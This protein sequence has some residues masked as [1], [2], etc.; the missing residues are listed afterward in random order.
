M[1]PGCNLLY[2]GYTMQ[3]KLI[4]VGI[5]LALVGTGVLFYMLGAS[6][7]RANEDDTSKTVIVDGSK[8][9]LIQRPP[10]VLPSTDAR[11]RADAI[12]LKPTEVTEDIMFGKSVEGREMHAYRFGNGPKKIILVGGIHGGYEWNTALLAF[13]MIDYLTADPGRVPSDLEVIIIPVANPD[14]LHKALGVVDRFNPDEA[15]DFEYAYEVSPEDIVYASRF[16]AHNVDI[17]RNFAC[18][19]RA[20][21]M[22]REYPVDAGPEAFSEPEAVFLRDLFLKE[23]P[24]AALFFHSASNGVYA[25]SCNGDP[26]PSTM[27]LLSTYSTA[28]GYPKFNDYPYYEVTGD[29]ADW[30]SSQGVPAI[31]IELSTHN[32]TEWDKNKAGLNAVFALYSDE[33]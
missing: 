15:P 26:L 29:A 14:G 24:I 1:A 13:E 23:S 2:N 4:P 17:N 30:F 27:E 6:S 5:L 25:S 19:R 7:N 16:N 9:D 32:V 8:V 11:L 31:T 22:W 20:V 18:D 21:G 28:S 3:K 33:R 12:E 10:I